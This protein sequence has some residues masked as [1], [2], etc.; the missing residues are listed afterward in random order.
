MKR[1]LILLTAIGCLGLS[2]QVWAALAPAAAKTPSSIALPRS[3][4]RLLTQETCQHFSYDKDPCNPNS[5][6]GLFAAPAPQGGWGAQLQCP[7]GIFRL[8]VQVFS[9][10]DPQYIL[11]R[12]LTQNGTIFG[13]AMQ[14]VTNQQGV[15]LYHQWES[16][17]TF[18]ITGNPPLIMGF[19]ANSGDIDHVEVDA[20]CCDTCDC[21]TGSPCAI[22]Y[23][24]PYYTCF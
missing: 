10:G 12:G 21:G 2:Q 23:A 16:V 20:C 11:L 22:G 9:C 1:E 13:G 8:K 7:S 18:G 19:T 24:L 15:L 3:Q 6:E 5:E 17:C 4:T 14:R